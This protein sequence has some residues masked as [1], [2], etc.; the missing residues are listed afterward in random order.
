MQFLRPSTK[1]YNNYHMVLNDIT[2]VFIKELLDFITVREVLQRCLQCELAAHLIAHRFIWQQ[3]SSSQEAL[4][5]GGRCKVDRMSPHVHT[6]A[7]VT[8]LMEER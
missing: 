1:D 7:G 6:K 2:P 5:M 3:C 4:T 8:R